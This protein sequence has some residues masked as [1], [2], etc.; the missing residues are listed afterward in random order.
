LESVDVMSNDDVP[1]RR[2]PI[3]DLLLGPAQIH[4]AEEKVPKKRSP[5]N[6]KK[7]TRVLDQ[8]NHGAAGVDLGASEV[9][10]AVGEHLSETPVRTFGTT[11]AELRASAEWMKSIGVDTVAMEATGV[12]WVPAYEIYEE[13]GLNP[14][15][16]NSRSIRSF[17]GMKKS[18][19][20]DCQWI[21]LLHTFGILQASMRVEAEMIE[22]RGYMRQRKNLV[23]QCSEQ[24][25]LMQKALILMN[26]RLDQAVSDITGATGL[27]ILRA[28]V[29]KGQRDPRKLAEMRDPACAKSEEQIAEALT[30]HYREEQL[31]ALDHALRL[32]D[33]CQGLMR[34]CDEHIDAL[35]KKLPIKQSR[36]TLP[37]ARLT[38]GK[39]RK[40][41]LRI[42]DGRALLYERLGVD[43]TLIAGLQVLTILTVLSECGFD[44]SRFP[45]AKHF[46][47]WLGLSPGTN[48]TGGRIISS[49]SR[50]TTNRAATALRLA[51]Q[52][53]LKTDT[54]LGAFGRRLRGRTGPEKAITAVAAKLA[55]R[56]YDSLRTGRAYA[57]RGPE[58]HDAIHRHRNLTSLTKRAKRFGMKL[59][60]IETEA[61]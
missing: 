30:G 51:A 6:L 19:Y 44:L 2:L 27:R 15:L 12:Y 21:H 7:N 60:P 53:L 41:E 24:I 39:A 11:T 20:I 58:Y 3:L 5:G 33:F 34:E 16:I 59:V 9:W 54:E 45:T 4:F 56:I 29:E 26:L 14:I 47:S 38:K 25:L 23:E 46:T 17:N 28:I 43:L 22:L 13:Y 35:L 48:I 49:R 50:R 55:H 10:V 37:N 18:D 57:D 1:F 61:A 8:I 36:E 42:E 52:S 40:N 31:L 32:W